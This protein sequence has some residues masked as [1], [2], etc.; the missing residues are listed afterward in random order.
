MCMYKYVNVCVC[1]YG[2]CVCVYVCTYVCN[3]TSFKT[4]P[5]NG[6][7]YVSYPEWLDP[8]RGEGIA[9]AV[10]W[11]VKGCIVCLYFW[12]TEILPYSHTPRVKSHFVF[13]YHELTFSVIFYEKSVEMISRSLENI[14]VCFNYASHLHK[15]DKTKNVFLF[16]S[17]SQK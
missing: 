12:S 2:V 7:T 17:S 15:I 5:H 13:L 11:Q 10:V 8:W 3:I 14:Y 6:F 1:M 9:A 16:E 4:P